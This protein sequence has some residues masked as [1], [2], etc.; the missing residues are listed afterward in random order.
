MKK[1]LIVKNKLTIYLFKSY[2]DVAEKTLAMKTRNLVK[3]K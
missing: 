3:K 2:S 1:L